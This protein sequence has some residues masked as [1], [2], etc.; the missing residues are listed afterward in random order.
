MI[1]ENIGRCTK[2]LATLKLT[3][4]QKVATA[5]IVVGKKSDGTPQI[6]TLFQDTIDVATGDIDGEDVETKLIQ[7]PSLKYTVDSK[8]VITAVHQ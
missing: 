5:K 1:R 3:K 4:V 7:A 6:F 8:G 2:C